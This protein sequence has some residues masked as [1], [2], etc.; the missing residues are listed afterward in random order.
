MISESAICLGDE[1]SR[2]DVPGGF[3]TPASAMGT[4]LIDRLVK[5]AGLTFDMIEA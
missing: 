1:I 4:K 3:W 2:D 5:N